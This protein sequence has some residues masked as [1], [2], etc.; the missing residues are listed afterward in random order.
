M[1][2]L[3]PEQRVRQQEIPDFVTP[4]VKDQRAPVTML[5]LAGVRMLVEF[6]AI[7]A[8]QAVGVF[9]KMPWYPVENHGQAVLVAGV[10]ERLEVVRRAVPR[11]R[12]EEPGDLVPPRAEKRMLHHRQELDVG[13]AHLLHVRNEP[14]GHL[15]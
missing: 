10:D 7:E 13:V 5:T 4:E 3:E 6:G 15:A 11:A 8:R 2:L 12:R 9:R 1:E 14:L